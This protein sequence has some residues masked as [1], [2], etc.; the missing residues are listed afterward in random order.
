MGCDRLG[1]GGIVLMPFLF[2]GG[3]V[4]VGD[5]KLL[6]ERFAKELGGWVGVGVVSK[7]YRKLRTMPSNTVLFHSLQATL[8]P[9][10]LTIVVNMAIN[11][12]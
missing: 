10:S 12:I 2:M 9:Q 6:Y 8:D 4:R 11:R 1:F 3:L 5:G 7:C